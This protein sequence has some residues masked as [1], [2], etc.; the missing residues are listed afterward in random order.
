MVH[1]VSLPAWPSHD[2]VY[3]PAAARHCDLYST[4]PHHP[5]SQGCSKNITTQPATQYSSILINI[6]KSKVKFSDGGRG[7]FVF[8]NFILKLM[9]P[10][11]CATRYIMYIIKL[12]VICAVQ[13]YT[14]PQHIYNLNCS[15]FC[16]KSGQ[17]QRGFCAEKSNPPHRGGCCCGA[18]RGKCQKVIYSTLFRSLCFLFPVGEYRRRRHT[19]INGQHKANFVGY[20]FFCIC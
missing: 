17:T 14:P 13:S 8:W 19:Q 2:D 12:F 4:H 16:Q 9:T 15:V 3:H 11:L 20:F 1:V 7:D 10:F 18:A 6:F 5:L